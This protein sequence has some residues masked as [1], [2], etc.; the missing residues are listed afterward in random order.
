MASAIATAADEV[1]AG[2]HDAEFVVDVFQTGSGTSTNMNANEV[3]AALAGRS[4]RRHPNDH[5]NRG[6]SSNDVFPPA[7]IWRRPRPVSASCCRRWTRSHGALEQKAG[8]VPDV[9]KIGST[10][11]AGRR[12][13][14]RW[15]RSSAATP[16][17]V[18]TAPRTIVAALDGIHELPL[19]GTA[20]GTGLNAPPGFA[21][22]AI[23]GDRRN[24]PACPSAKRANHFEAQ[25]GEGCRA[26][27]ERRR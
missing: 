27:S 22:A 9:L 12:A 18:E 3:I 23:S 7:C 5:V 24:A 8:R 26:F 6:Q 21:A 15:A 2:R 14:A 17:Q 25:A 4:G 10:H 19:G 11:L 13:H 16:R 1:A 20:V